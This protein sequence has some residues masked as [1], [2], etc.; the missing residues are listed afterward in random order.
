MELG[1]RIKQ[2]ALEREDLRKGLSDLL[3]MGTGRK[4]RS[5]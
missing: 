5:L 2:R 4:G 3:E 1:P